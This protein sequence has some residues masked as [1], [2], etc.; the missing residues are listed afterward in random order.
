MEWQLSTLNLSWQSVLLWGEFWLG[1]VFVAYW[2][3]L[4]HLTLNDGQQSRRR[5]SD[6]P[7]TAKIHDGL[8]MLLWPY[9]VAVVAY[10]HITKVSPVPSRWLAPCGLCCIP[11]GGL[12]MMN[13]KQFSALWSTQWLYRSPGRV[14][15]GGLVFL[16]WGIFLLWGGIFE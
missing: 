2:L 10:S 5:E 7:P 1:L 16:V 4:G 13:R 9:Y 14:M 6:M 15:G 12:M 11:M 8:G 3:P